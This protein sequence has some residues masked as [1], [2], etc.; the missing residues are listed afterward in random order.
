MG[1]DVAIHI[2]A[3][4][5]DGSAALIR[6]GTS[7]DG[8]HSISFGVI[9]AHGGTED[10]AVSA[11]THEGPGQDVEGISA[12]ECMKGMRALA[13]AVTANHFRGVTVRPAR[14]RSAHRDPVVITG[15]AATTWIALPQGREPGPLEQAALAVLKLEGAHYQ[16]VALDDDCTKPES[17]MWA[18]DVAAH[19][20]KLLLVLR[21]S[22]C[23]S[24]TKMEVTA[25]VPRA[26]GY[27]ALGDA[28][29]SGP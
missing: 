11:T 16:T 27:V 5:P 15:G 29:E 14:C 23:N 6:T 21:T 20:E 2:V 19:S 17:A 9:S 24:P 25:Y 22:R 1:S 8:D 3:W 12:K 10:I 7:R 13:A 4:N 28:A 18:M 26:G